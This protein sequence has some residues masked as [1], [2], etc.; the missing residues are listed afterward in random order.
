MDRVKKKAKSLPV[1][2][3]DP[4]AIAETSPL[5]RHAQLPNSAS[6]LSYL[7]PNP[8]WEQCDFQYSLRAI[9]RAIRIAM[10]IA[11]SIVQMAIKLL[12][13]RCKLGALRRASN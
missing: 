12:W 13:V 9:Q 1:L 3:D 6:G 5:F 10:R 2:Q 7:D 8:L 4:Q 11:K